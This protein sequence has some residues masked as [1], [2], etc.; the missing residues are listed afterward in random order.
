MEDETL[1]IDAESRVDILQ[2]PTTI[3]DTQIVGYYAQSIDA[4]SNDKIVREDF[5]YTS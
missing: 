5:Y 1:N 3:D 2:N 4:L